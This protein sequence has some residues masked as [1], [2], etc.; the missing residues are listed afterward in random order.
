MI[1]REKS[2]S[3]IGVLIY[4]FYMHAIEIIGIKHS[5][6]QPKSDQW[7]E[8][9]GT[10]ELIEGLISGLNTQIGKSQACRP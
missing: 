5:T 3:I 9:N 8:V 4:N 2:V 6:G 7:C 1:Y 10:Q